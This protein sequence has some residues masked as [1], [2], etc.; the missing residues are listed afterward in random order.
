M[1]L[2][3]N[4]F[5]NSQ[6]QIFHVLLSFNIFFYTIIQRYVV[7]LNRPNNEEFF[8]L[9]NWKQLSLENSFDIVWYNNF[10]HSQKVE[11]ANKLG[12]SS[13][14]YY[15][16]CKNETLRL[17]QYNYRTKCSHQNALSE[18]ESQLQFRL[19]PLQELYI[20]LLALPQNSALRAAQPP[21]RGEPQFRRENCTTNFKKNIYKPKNIKRVW[22]PNLS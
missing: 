13:Q 9:T 20:A 12:I 8:E 6:L 7:S 1:C 10:V 5:M 19:P 18:A 15:K 16:I 22:V 17:L 11:Q 21:L 14:L 3:I 4:I 2:Y